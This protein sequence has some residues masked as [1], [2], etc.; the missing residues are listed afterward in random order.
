M[1]GLEFCDHC[2]LGKSYR[3]KFETS[4]HVSSRPFKYTH[5]DLWGPTRAQTHGERSYFLTILDDH[6]G[7]GSI[8]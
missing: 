5:I 6:G 1:E 3:L 7:C 4:K 2:I 8:S